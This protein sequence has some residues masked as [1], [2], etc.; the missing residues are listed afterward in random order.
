M[1]NWEP[2]GDLKEGHGV[3]LCE[4]TL[5]YGGYI[6]GVR[7]GNQIEIDFNGERLELP[8]SLFSHYSEIQ[9]PEE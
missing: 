6:F 2:I 1:I 5:N 8:I 4:K 7:Y 3:L 9:M